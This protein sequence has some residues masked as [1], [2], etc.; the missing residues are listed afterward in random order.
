MRD[1]APVVSVDV[2]HP[3]H[4]AVAAPDVAVR[5]LRD[6]HC[7]GSRAIR[8]HAQT[9]RKAPAHLRLRTTMKA[10]MRMMKRAMTVDDPMGAFRG[11]TQAAQSACAWP[12]KHPPLALD[13]EHARAADQVMQAAAVV[14]KDHQVIDGE[15][16]AAQGPEE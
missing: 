16:D 4:H 2:G 1:G 11:A 5:E 15:D 7:S 10:A 3:H 14:A 12:G 13:P 9:V 8:T 6:D